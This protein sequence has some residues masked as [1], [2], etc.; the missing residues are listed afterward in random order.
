VVATIITLP[1]LAAYGATPSPPFQALA[2]L[3]RLNAPAGSIVVTGHFVFERYLQQIRDQEVLLPTEGARSTLMRHWQ[4]GNRKPVLFFTDP[5]RTTLLLFGHDRQQRVGRWVWP[6]AVQPFMQG[7][8]PGRVELLYLEAPSWFAER[9]FLLS[10]EAGPLETVVKEMPRLDVLASPRR[11][12]LVVSGFLYGAGTADVALRLPERRSAWTVGERFTLRTLLEP[13][14]NPDGYV[15]IS[16]ETSAPA[17]FTDVWLEP[18]DRPFM[19]PSHGFYLPERDEDAELF[20]WAAPQ[21]VATAYLPVSKGRVTIEGWMPASYY[22]L[23][24][25]LSLDWNGQAVASFALS[26][27]RFRVEQ[28][29][30]GSPEMPWGEL[31]IRVSQSFVPHERQRNGDRRTLSVRIYRLTLDAG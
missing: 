1:A 2:A 10:D 29:V 28:D 8:R 17:V 22:Q 13:L 21:A 24:L 30:G 5:S 6:A 27:P 4:Q 11:R 16:F 15:P 3:E 20:R 9:G 14:V 25:R 31:A 7:E 23:P 26:T 18:A 12:A 19:R